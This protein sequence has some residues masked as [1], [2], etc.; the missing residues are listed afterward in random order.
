MPPPRI[1]EWAEVPGKL[2]QQLSQ[3]FGDLKK[4]F[5]D[6]TATIDGM[7]SGYGNGSPSIDDEDHQRTLDMLSDQLYCVCENLSN[8]RSTYSDHL[9]LKLWALLYLLPEEA[10]AELRLVRS[11]LADLDELQLG[12]SASGG[13]EAFSLPSQNAAQSKLATTA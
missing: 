2:P 13:Q 12:H 3:D 6:L 10:D 8:L 7:S 5:H 9:K 1:D 4:S 11:L